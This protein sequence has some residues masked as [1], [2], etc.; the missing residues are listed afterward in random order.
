LV[1]PLLDLKH[2]KKAGMAATPLPRGSSS[3]ALPAP[4]RGAQAAIAALDHGLIVHGLLGLH[5]QDSARGSFSVTVGQGL[6]VEKG[7]VVGRAKAI[8]AGNFFEALAQTPT[9][10]SVPGKEG[11][12]LSIDCE[13]LPG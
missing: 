11:L 2:A 6:V 4:T 7:V 5:T 3:F 1:T 13:V 12:A 8:I 10:L 9:F